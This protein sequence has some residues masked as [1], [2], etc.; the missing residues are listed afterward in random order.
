MLL[1]ETH[2]YNS[3]DWEVNEYITCF[4]PSFGLLL[5]Y[6]TD[7]WDDVSWLAPDIGEYPPEYFN[8]VQR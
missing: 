5:D 1:V 7:G 4:F 6:T 8:R 2:Y 3:E